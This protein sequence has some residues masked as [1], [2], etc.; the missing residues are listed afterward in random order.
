[1]RLTFI[2]IL[3]A[4]ISFS[5]GVYAG[6]QAKNPSQSRVETDPKTGALL[7]IVNGREEARVDA[8]G[9]HVRHD[10]EYGNTITDIG[11]AS[12]IGVSAKASHAP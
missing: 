12:D 11:G 3:L 6:N 10:I 5:A 7:F 4:C 8:V 2:L 1:M 9:L